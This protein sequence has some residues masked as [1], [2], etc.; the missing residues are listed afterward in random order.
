MIVPYERGTPVHPSSQVP[1]PAPG[2]ILAEAGASRG[3]EHGLS[4]RR[5]YVTVLFDDLLTP[6]FLFLFHFLENDHSKLSVFF[7]QGEYWLK[8][9]PPGAVNT[10]CHIVA[11]TTVRVMPEE[12]KTHSYAC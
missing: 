5:T 6:A 12:V 7:L 9:G 10:D 11:H 1:N 8:K 2:G 3:G 4:Y